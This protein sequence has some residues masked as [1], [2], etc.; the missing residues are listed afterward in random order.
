VQPRQREAILDH[1][2]RNFHAHRSANFGG[3]L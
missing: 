1:R 2:D 3:E